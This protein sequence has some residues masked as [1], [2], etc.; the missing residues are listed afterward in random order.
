MTIV[1]GSCA[2]SLNKK[3]FWINKLILLN[4]LTKNSSRIKNFARVT[5]GSSSGSA[6]S[7]TKNYQLRFVF[8]NKEKKEQKLLISN[9]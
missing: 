5:S 9:T 7:K 2:D 1:T 3:K 6:L 4:L 8:E